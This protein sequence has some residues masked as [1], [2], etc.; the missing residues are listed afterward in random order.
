MNIL[1][2]IISVQK[3]LNCISILDFR[4]AKITVKRHFY[5]ILNM[6]SKEL[7]NSVDGALVEV[8]STVK[9]SGFTVWLL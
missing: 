2:V 8:L 7:S 3:L 4:K 1:E 6:K 9:P 5:R